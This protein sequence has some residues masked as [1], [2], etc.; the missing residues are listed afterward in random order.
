MT[1]IVGET[2]IGK[3]ESD[4]VDISVTILGAGPQGPPGQ[5]GAP[6]AD[7]KDG[8]DGYTPIKGVDYFD[9][10]DGYTPVKGVDYFDGKDGEKGEP[11]KDGYTP[12]KGVDYFDGEKGDP[13]ESPDPSIFALKE[14]LEAMGL[15]LADPVIVLTEAEFETITPNPAKIYILY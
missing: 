10:K 6:G 14:D 11:G 8:A 1:K 12:V 15:S 3:I 5:N 13:G 9:G 4:E 2:L 7:G